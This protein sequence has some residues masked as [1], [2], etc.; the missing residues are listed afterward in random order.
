MGWIAVANSIRSEPRAGAAANIVARTHKVWWT[1][2]KRQ[3]IKAARAW[4]LLAVV[5]SGRVST[6]MVVDLS[7]EIESTRQEGR[8]NQRFG[9]KS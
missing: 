8:V 4:E 7:L 3:S 5:A 9:V 1:L 6:V 2:R